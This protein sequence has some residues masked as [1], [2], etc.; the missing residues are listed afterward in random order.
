MHLLEVPTMYILSN[1]SDKESGSTAVRVLDHMYYSVVQPYGNYK[2]HEL[3]YTGRGQNN[4]KI[5][6]AMVID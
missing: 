3:Y 1:N 2:M 4:P 6:I 5:G